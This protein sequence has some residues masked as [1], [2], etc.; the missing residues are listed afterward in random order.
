MEASTFTKGH[1]VSSFD[2]DV[3]ITGG[4]G[5]LIC[6]SGPEVRDGLIANVQG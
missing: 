1:G 5:I 4:K 2:N 3:T 6:Q